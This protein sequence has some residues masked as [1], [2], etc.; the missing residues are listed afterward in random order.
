MKTYRFKL[1]F[2]CLKYLVYEV[3]FVDELDEHR[4]GVFSE[5][6]NKYELF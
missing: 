6:N 5:R 2:S 1:A 3:Y 4:N